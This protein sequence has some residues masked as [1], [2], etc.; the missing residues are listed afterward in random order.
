MAQ[1]KR[2]SDSHHFDYYAFCCALIIGNIVK[3]LPNMLMCTVKRVSLQE[4]VL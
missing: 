4:G 2:A 1:A 3:H